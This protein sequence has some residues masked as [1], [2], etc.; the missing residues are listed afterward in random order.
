LLAQLLAGPCQ[1]ET[2]SE[3]VF[4]N[5]ER[6]EEEIE[7]KKRKEKVKKD[8]TRERT[9]GREENEGDN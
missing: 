2:H 4:K 7:G 1:E 3:E 8:E 9:K 5:R 6:I